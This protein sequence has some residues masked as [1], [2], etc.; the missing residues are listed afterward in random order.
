MST[1]F[2][3]VRCLQCALREENAVIGNDTYGVTH[4]PG[5]PTNKCNAV[6]FFEFVE[7]AP[8]DDTG[9]HFTHVVA[10]AIICR[11]DAKEVVGIIAWWYWWSNI[12]GNV[13]ATIEMGDN[14]AAYSQGVFIIE[15]V[16]VG[17]A[18]NTTVNIG[19]TQLLRG[20]LFTRCCLYQ[21]R[22]SQENGAIAAHNHRFITHGRNICPTRGARTHNG[23]NLRYALA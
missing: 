1:Q 19:A 22:P 18:R 21:W 14:A 2:D 12:P 13:F 4:E 17:Y 8:I 5:K 10:P 16:V 11:D 15:G 6:Q 3:E 9:N 23:R 20:N 7:F